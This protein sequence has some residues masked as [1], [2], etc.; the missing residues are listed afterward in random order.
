[1][2]EISGTVEWF[3]IGVTGLALAGAAGATAGLAHVAR[4]ILRGPT[5]NAA[6]SGWDLQV[7]SGPG[8]WIL[9]GALILA[10]GAI[11]HAV[12][13]VGTVV[14]EVGHVAES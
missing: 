3:A 1:M 2:G 8:G 5:E 12:S 11:H 9:F 13:G 10:G 7:I 6:A 4:E 14:G